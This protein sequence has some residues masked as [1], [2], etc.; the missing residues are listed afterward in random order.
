MVRWSSDWQ[1]GWSNATGKTSPQ[2]VQSCWQA[3]QRTGINVESKLL[4]FEYAFETMG[5]VRVDLKTD[6]RNEQSRRAIEA[7]GAQFEGVL[8]GWSESHAPGEQSLL[9]DSAMFSVI[10]SEW[11]RVKSHLIKRLA[12]R[13]RSPEDR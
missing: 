6:A 9:R 2:V 4:L 5:V 10:A 8:R 1:R 3:T 12:G 11:P 13:D 7:L